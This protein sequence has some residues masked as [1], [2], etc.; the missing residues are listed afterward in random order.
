MV[1]NV[2]LTRKI[3]KAIFDVKNLN[4]TPQKLL[5]RL[6]EYSFTDDDT[7]EEKNE[8]EASIEF[9]VVREVWQV[10]KKNSLESGSNCSP[11]YLHELLEGSELYVPPPKP[12]EKSPELVARLKKLRTQYERVQ[13]NAMVANISPK[14]LRATS[15]Q[16]SSIVSFLISIIAAFMFGFVA[17]QYGFP[18]LAMRVIMGIIIACVVAIA[19]IY[20]MARTEI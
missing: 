7:N 17:S 20:F 19:E 15:K 9:S 4:E 10:L 12:P 2:S 11:V 18:S 5:D 1:V 16:L 14:V 8:E 6:S 13:Y 3:Q